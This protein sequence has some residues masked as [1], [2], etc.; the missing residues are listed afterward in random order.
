[1]VSDLSYISERDKMIWLNV[2]SALKVYPNMEEVF[3]MM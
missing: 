1:M 2:V 3:E